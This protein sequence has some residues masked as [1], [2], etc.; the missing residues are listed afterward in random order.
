MGRWGYRLF[1]GDQDLD[2]FH[3]LACGIAEENG[4]PEIVWLFKDGFF[5]SY[6]TPGFV[7]K[8]SNQPEGTDALKM[9]TARRIFDSGLGAGLMAKY[10]ALENS[11]D[12]RS[13]YSNKYVVI[14]LGAIFVRIGAQ[15][16]KA[17][18]EHLRQLALA[19]PSRE[20][21]ALPLWDDGFRG[22]G[23]RQFIA[24]LDGYQAGTPHDFQGPSCFACGKAKDHIGTE[25]LSCGRCHFAWFCNKVCHS[26]PHFR[27]VAAC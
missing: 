20:G 5:P 2:I 26:S 21:F 6:P 7:P 25:V 22:P 24:A 23:L 17:D 12:S 8:E 27:W 4:S 3:D 11:G 9:A 1:E 10:R 15:M 14:I 19:T 16:S 18:V 13:F